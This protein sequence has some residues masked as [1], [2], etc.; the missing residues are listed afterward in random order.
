MGIEINI[1][2][3]VFHNLVSACDGITLKIAGSV[4]IFV[5]SAVELEP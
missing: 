3:G 5:D 2:V 4:A 1:P